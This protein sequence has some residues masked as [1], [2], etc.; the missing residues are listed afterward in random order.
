[1]VIGYC[2]LVIYPEPVEGLVI[3]NRKPISMQIYK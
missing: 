2:L 1:M 3:E